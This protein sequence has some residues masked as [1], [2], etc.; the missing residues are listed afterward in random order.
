MQELLPRP[1]GSVSLDEL[2]FLD[3]EN[4]RTAEA[5]LRG[6]HGREENKVQE[7]TVPHVLLSVPAASEG[8]VRLLRMSCTR[9]RNSD[10]D[11]SLG[12]VVVFCWVGCW[13][14]GIV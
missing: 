6:V 12:V 11:Q 7:A 13:G 3:E 1:Q 10:S 5:A 14:A 2:P 8:D 4:R 9:F